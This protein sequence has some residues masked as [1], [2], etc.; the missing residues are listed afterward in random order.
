MYTKNHAV[1][2]VFMEILPKWAFASL[3]PV[4]W[5]KQLTHNKRSCHI[6]R[7]NSADVQLTFLAILIHSFID[8]FLDISKLNSDYFEP[9][10]TS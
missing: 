6:N 2:I 7:L 4:I 5:I 1:L 8:I 3:F 10:K 9:T